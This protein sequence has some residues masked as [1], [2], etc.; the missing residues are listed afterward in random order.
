MKNLLFTGICLAVMAHHSS[1]T[2]PQYSIAGI[3]PPLLRNANSVIR[4]HET[5]FKVTDPDHA[6]EKVHY[7]ITLLNSKA[8][9]E[10]EIRVHYDKSS[11]VR[12]LEFKIFDALGTDITRSYRKLETTDESAISDGTLYS[13]S[14][15]KVVSPVIAQYPVTLEYSYERNFS[16]VFQ[17]PAWAPIQTVNQSL[18][19]A[20]FTLITPHTL[21]PRFMEVNLVPSAVTRSENETDYYSWHIS[22]ITAIEDESFDAPFYELIPYLLLAPGQIKYEN[23]NSAFQDWKDLG[24]FQSYLV[25][26]RDKLSPETVS[27][28]QELVKACPDRI[29]KIKTVYK[30]MQS[31]TRYVGVQIGIGGNQPIPADFVD[32]K[33]YGDCKGLVNYTKAMLKAV[34]IE[35]FYTLVNAGRNAPPVITAFPCDRFDHIILCVPGSPDTTWLECTNQQQA[36]GFLG[37]FTQDRNALL[38][39]PDGGR[40]VHTP[41]YAMSQNTSFRKAGIRLDKDGNAEAH[42]YTKVNGLQSENV[43]AVYYEN[44]EE[45]RK[46]YYK[47]SGLADSRISSLK[48]TLSGDFL[49]QGTEEVDLFIPAFASRSSNRYFMPA[50]LPD[51]VN[52]VPAYTSARTSPLVIRNEFT[53]RDTLE[54]S[55]PEGFVIE[56]KPEKQVIE[57][58]FGSYS[59]IV[60]NIGDK[61][62]CIRSFS[63]YANRFPAAEYADFIVFMKKITKADQTKIVLFQKV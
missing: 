45:Q 53:D 26:G 59:L 44:P 42:I 57:T 17:Y 63:I 14:R 40:M 5:T 30:Y 15:C 38:I 49:P 60:E 62:V 21:K 23:Y 52:R 16:M 3:P 28:L 10:A 37:S 41:K 9:D 39:T 4:L 11:S 12:N 34:G 2:G 51:R 58:K 56:F 29:S 13:D 27:K 54:F 20:G 55:L 35:S 47:R 7:V 25:E 46:G 31:R 6:S 43:E 32:K 61:L 19:E 1:A 50:V 18:Q 48:Y 24:K 36:F 22:N 33:G 8:S